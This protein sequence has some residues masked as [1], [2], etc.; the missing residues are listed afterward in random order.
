M[1]REDIAQKWLEQVN[2]DILTAEV[3]CNSGRWLYVGFLCHQAVEKL[4]KAYWFAAREDEPMY[5]HNHFRLLEG[6]G[7]KPQLTDAQ[8]R[9]LEIMSPMYIAGRYPEYKNQVARMLNEKGSI[10]L[11]EQTKE[12][13]QWILQECSAVTKL[14]ASSDDTNK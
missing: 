12:F 1:A 11:I 3:L 5:L 4:I 14:S 2:E 9:F 8:R 6:C 13:R 10:Y 7:L